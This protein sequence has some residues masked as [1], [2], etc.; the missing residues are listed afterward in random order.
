MAVVDPARA[1]LPVNTGMHGIVRPSPSLRSADGVQALVLG[2]HHRALPGSVEPAAVV[3]I[4]GRGVAEPEHGPVQAGDDA[5]QPVGQAPG[6]VDERLAPATQLLDRL[7][8]GQPDGADVQQPP[9]HLLAGRGIGDDVEHGRRPSLPVG[10]TDHLG[11]HP[12]VLADLGQQLA[13]V[14]R[15]RRR[16]RGLA[17]LV[18]QTSMAAACSSSS[19]A[20]SARRRARAPAASGAMCTTPMGRSRYR[21]PTARPAPSVEQP[22]G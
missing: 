13:G 8:V 7:Q 2:A 3:E 15:R 14:A 4:G 11:P 20:T 6:E 17:R 22:W 16:H 1:A 10:G 18:E 21:S 19:D 12:D 5:A 9:A